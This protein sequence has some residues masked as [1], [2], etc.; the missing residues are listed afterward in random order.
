MRRWPA[1][2]G[3]LFGLLCGLPWS[4][5]SGCSDP[6][7]QVVVRVQTDIPPAS[8]R[9]F[10]I[11]VW[12]DAAE[13]GTCEANENCRAQFILPSA[14]AFPNGDGPAGFTE[15]GSFGVSPL[16]EGEDPTTRRFEVRVHVLGQIDDFTTR[17]ITSFVRDRTVYLDVFV[18]EACFDLECPGDQTC[19]ASGTCVDP[20]VA[21]GRLLLAPTDVSMD[22]REPDSMDGGLDGGVE[23]PPDGA[24]GIDTNVD[25][26]DA[27][28]VDAGRGDSGAMDAALDAALDAGYDAMP[29]ALLPDAARPDAPG[30]VDRIYFPHHGYRFGG[31]EMTFSMRAA[32]DYSGSVVPLMDLRPGLG[33]CDSFGSG[34]VRGRTAGMG[35]FDLYDL[36]LGSRGPYCATVCN[37]C[38]AE[39]P[40]G[41]YRY[42]HAG[43]PRCD[44]DNDGESNVVGADADID[45]LAIDGVMRDVRPGPQALA[46][47]NFLG[48]EAD[49]IAIGYVALNALDLLDSPTEP[50]LAQPATS[51]PARAITAGDLNG[52]GRDDLIVATASGL[53]VFVGGATA[54][55]A[56]QDIN[57]AGATAN[58]GIAIA[59][60][61]IDADGFVEIVVGQAG[62]APASDEA[63]FIIDDALG[64]P[65]VHRINPPRVGTRFGFS[66]AGLD[67]F[68]GDAV[69]D[70]AV[71]AP[72][73][74]GRVYVYRG[75]VDNPAVVQ[76]RWSELNSPAAAPSH[77]GLSVT[78][79]GPDG[80]V[81]H[82]F[83]VVGD[84]GENSGAGGVHFFDR[85]GVVM[86]FP[87][88][89]NTGFGYALSRYGWTTEP[90][91]FASQDDGRIHRV[92]GTT[93]QM[94][95]GI[96]KLLP[97]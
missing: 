45:T 40:T 11:E 19:G 25:A 15:V 70:F 78:D 68:D 66:V 39:P 76:S 53:Q 54:L 24:F 87:G 84:P 30:A 36:A 12:S 7:T 71:G 46:C 38:M 93:A 42:V 29:D 44:I 73:D 94:V 90:I 5:V 62:V 77:F 4:P 55:G 26:Q 51:A 32:F 48:D 6:I 52:D 47:G 34:Q 72:H 18:A 91:V 60:T 17:V 75:F 95:S 85:S 49:E 22:P 33:A 74:G 69:G 28:S 13:P 65:V 23:L 63:V 92:D 86:S 89:A 16:A 35:Y 56:P 2:Y 97:R 61:D 10:E 59:T 43:H 67:D 27:S 14:Q 3:L 21:P 57:V 8:F 58:F 82:S 64:S 1:R 50:V 37:P 96:G 31:S 80:T 9:Q 83:V 79:G 20:V 41:D 88:G 81:G